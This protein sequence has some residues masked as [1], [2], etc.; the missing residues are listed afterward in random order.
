M[1]KFRLLN[2]DHPLLRTRFRQI[3][4]AIQLA[5]IAGILNLL[6]FDDY[7]FVAA[8]P[9][10]LRFDIQLL[11]AGIVS[12]LTAFALVSRGRLLLASS[13]YLWLC[14]L[15][16]VYITWLEG[17][18][19]SLI[20]LCFPVILIFAALY[21]DFWVFLSISAFLFISV[22]LMGLNHSYDWYASPPDLLV[23]GAPRTVSGLIVIALTSYIAWLCGETLKESMTR[24]ALENK[25]VKASK[26]MI[27][28]LADFDVLTGLLNRTAAEGAYQELLQRSDQNQSVIMY[29]IDLDNFKSINDA[30][31]HRAGD[32]LLKVIAKRLQ[33]LLNGQSIAGR[34]GGD[35]FIIV[36][37]EDAQFDHRE[38][39]EKIA[40]E[41]AE[42]FD[43]LGVELA[44]TASIGV[45]MLSQ[46]HLTFEE[47]LRCADMAMYQ[48][49]KLGKNQCHYYCESLE[50]QYMRNLNIVSGLKDAVSHDLLDLHF[51][52]K[53]DL[54]TGQVCGAE[55]LLRWSRCNPEGFRPDEFIPVI[56][57]TDLIHDIGRWV[58]KE[59]CQ[60]C[61]QWHNAGYPLSVAVNVSATQ[62]SHPA[63]YESVLDALE[64][65]ELS[66]EYLEIELTEHCL[67][68]ES[69]VVNKQLNLLKELGIQLAI[70]DFGTG[71]SNLGY[72]TRLQV[73]VL[74]LD[75]SFIAQISRSADSLAIV[76][77]IIRMAKTLRMHVVAEGVETIAE[78][79]VLYRLDCEY[80]QG[81]LWSKPEPNQT[82]MALLAN[83]FGGQY[84]T[85]EQTA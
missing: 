55:A 77:A 5:L 21:V 47:A 26:E 24:L 61:K 12:T 40:R 54:Q 16:L 60:Y 46:R 41:V 66:T 49:K 31:N 29:F 34:L 56:E 74:K 64:R 78:R 48:A 70:D 3:L 33:S 82:F 20:I 42:P 28:K 76:K 8:S 53:I 6:I 19:H 68:N 32:E 38:F 65:S 7:L 43:F 50:K 79:D 30:F 81:Y 58:V 83:S 72:L 44:V 63:F 27:K 71:Y 10:S 4:W 23:T 15:M 75:R 85:F 1:N 13:L 36:I 18:L 80:G 69:P 35:E 52:P 67:V 9:Y 25:Q 84:P 57:S 14:A 37:R 11:G 2:K 45:A 73:D 22:L 59:A 17:G 39:A 51:Q 62:L